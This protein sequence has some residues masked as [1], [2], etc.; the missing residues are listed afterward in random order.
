MERNSL[1]AQVVESV[2]QIL[3]VRRCRDRLNRDR[4]LQAVLLVS[5]AHVDFF[6]A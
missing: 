5:L 1:G 2:L 4:E 3:P 6:R